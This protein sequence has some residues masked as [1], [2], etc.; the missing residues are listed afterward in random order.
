MTKEGRCR[1][2]FNRVYAQTINLGQPGPGLERTKVT[3]H[4]TRSVLSDL[5]APRWSVIWSRSHSDAQARAEEH[6]FHNRRSRQAKANNHQPSIK[7]TPRARAAIENIKEVTH[8][9]AQTQK[10]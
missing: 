2:L 10:P 4:R 9:Y 5:P 6:L 3:A 7:Q 8:I 1:K